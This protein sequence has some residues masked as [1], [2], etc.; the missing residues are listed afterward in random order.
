MFSAVDI[1]KVD[2]GGWRWEKNLKGGANLGKIAF[3]G[4]IEFSKSDYL[5]VG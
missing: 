4:R 5:S 1:I 2:Q 3:D